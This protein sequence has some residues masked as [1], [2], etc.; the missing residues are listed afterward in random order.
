MRLRAASP[1]DA[2]AVAALLRMAF[3][4]EAEAALVAALHAEGAVA[5]ELVAEAAQGGILGHVLFSPMRVGGTPALA[6]APLSVVAAARRRGI[7]AALVREGLA[8][9]ASRSEGW[10]LVLGEPGYYGRFGFSAAAAS[11]VAGVPWAGHPAFQALRLRD[12]APP[13]SGAARYACA[14]GL[15]PPETLSSAT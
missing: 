3:D 8:R 5:I 7:G 1:V 11:G 6:L 12:D 10:C 9:A 15:P 14:F 4:G 13:L 2:P